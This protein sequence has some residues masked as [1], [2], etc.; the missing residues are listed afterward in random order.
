MAL[1]AL[2]TSQADAGY[3]TRA[4]GEAAALH[5]TGIALHRRI[6][7]ID[8]VG[9]ATAIAQQLMQ[10]TCDMKDLVYANAEWHAVETQ[11]LQ[12]SQL[13]GLLIQRVAACPVL[14]VDRRTRR[15]L[16]TFVDRYANLNRDLQRALAAYR[17]PIP[18]CRTGVPGTF[19]WT[20]PTPYYAPTPVVPQNF[21]G[22]QSLHPTFRNRI[23]TP[24]IA[25]Q[26][27]NPI[28]QNQ[29]FGFPSGNPGVVNGPRLEV[30]SGNDLKS[31]L[32]QMLIRRVL[33]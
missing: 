11:L 18:T 3:L 22:R 4:R 1:F 17:P 9:H 13:N 26:S 8:S 32:V 23:Q 27:L 6:C 28:P 24:Q 14:G 15:E 21:Q 25:P 16:E 31:E 7:E 10:A 5:R 30:R 12:I 29:G 33:N 2:P 19:P 20:S